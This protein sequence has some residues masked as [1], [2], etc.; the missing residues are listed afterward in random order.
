ME[1]FKP[2]LETALAKNQLALNNEQIGQLA[3]YLQLLQTW[4]KVFN[5]TNITNPL[6]M[7]ELHIIDSLLVQP[8]LHGKN[9]LDVG[10]GAGLP[11]IPLAVLNPDQKWV[12]LDKNNKKTR[13][14]QQAVAELQLDN[15]SIVHARTEEFHPEAGF[16][17]ILSRAFASLAVFVSTTKHLLA[18]DGIFLAMKG[19]YPQ[20][21]LAE[22]A[23]DTYQC[24]VNEI[25][26]K[27]RDVKRHIVIIRSTN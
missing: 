12:L 10:S 22:L 19:Q 1:N 20:D 14:M 7:V 16:D 8:Y 23:Q 5:L 21:E 15:V 2:L 18:A 11:G 4:N 27:G 13:F 9:M 17:S 24:Q 6:D 25:L 26:I 3:Q